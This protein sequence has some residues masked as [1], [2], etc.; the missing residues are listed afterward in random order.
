[1]TGTT[2]QASAPATAQSASA[3]ST[4]S[5]PDPTTVLT[6][7]ASTAKPA[8]GTQP[9]AAAATAKA[10]EAKTGDDGKGGEPSKTKAPET[11]KFEFSDPT[12]KVD[13][14]TLAA[15]TPVLQKHNVTQEQA[16]ELAN[17]LA[18]QNKA[19]TDAY[20]KKLE[21]ETF[22]TE[23]AGLMLAAQRDKWAA[24]LKSDK[25]I[26]GTNYETNVKA[27]QRAIA[28]FG[29][30]ALKTLL[31]QT[32]L[33]N[34]PALARFC[35]K[36]GLTISEDKVLDGGNSGGGSRKSNEEVFYGGQSA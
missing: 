13:D 19:Q 23:Q 18:V 25:D 3:S 36:A 33:G 17:V 32:G 15:F 1:M 24:A 7:D 28:R 14:A 34:H 22:A 27:M 9:A 16:Q 31:E 11:Y 12:V 10:G 5:T 4:A 2:A 21:D 8:D 6:G 30:P 29:D 35:L 20:T 26:G